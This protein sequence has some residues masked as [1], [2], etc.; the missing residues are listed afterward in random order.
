MQVRSLDFISSDQILNTETLQAYWQSDGME[1]SER[2]QLTIKAHR[3]AR[4]AG[5][6]EV[7]DIVAAVEN[8]GITMPQDNLEAAKKVGAMTVGLASLL[9]FGQCPTCLPTE[10]SSDH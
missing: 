9:H 2:Q 8:A 1:E 10:R 5:L 6:K 7:M 4:E 3:A